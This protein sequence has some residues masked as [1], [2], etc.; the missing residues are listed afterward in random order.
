MSPAAGT[1]AG[2]QTNANQSAG[3][4]E[5]A[6]PCSSGIAVVLCPMRC[7]MA[8]QRSVGPDVPVWEFNHAET[9]GR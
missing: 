7:F 9:Y 4:V 2:G 3:S 5:R 8:D 1:P 6:T